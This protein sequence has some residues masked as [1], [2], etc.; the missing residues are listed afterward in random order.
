M[1]K[2]IAVLVILLLAMPSCS[3]KQIREEAPEEPTPT[4]SATQEI[5]QKGREVKPKSE[6]T[7]KKEARKITESTDAQKPDA[8]PNF[9]A[10]R[11][12]KRTLPDDFKIGALQDILEGSRNQLEITSVAQKFLKALCSGKIEEQSLLPTKRKELSRFLSYYIEQDMIPRRFRIGRLTIQDET[13]L[14][15]EVWMNVRLFGM[16]GVAEGELYLYKNEGKW[17][18]SDIQIGFEL[19]NRTYTR[20]DEKFMPSYSGWKLEGN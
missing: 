20:E 12:G 2:W 15:N 1:S 18:I 16:I 9:L 11:S 19:L 14:N 17:Y 6:I 5:A 7:L 10:L 3:K 4:P 8:S 13:D